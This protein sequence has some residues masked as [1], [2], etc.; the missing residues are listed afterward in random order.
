[1]KN[2]NLYVEK[3]EKF[4]KEIEKNYLMP[5]KCTVEEVEN[6]FILPPKKI[7]DNN[8]NGIYAGGVA[9]SK[10]EFVAGLIRKYNDK[11]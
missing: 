1:M 3:K 2:Y 11:I 5:G 4:Q 10:G 9:D 8:K 6:G 7:I